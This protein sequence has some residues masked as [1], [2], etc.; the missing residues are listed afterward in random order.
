M[1]DIPDDGGTIEVMMPKD[2]LLQVHNQ[3]CGWEF[4]KK[5]K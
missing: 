1:L 5:K 3:R 4:K 2:H